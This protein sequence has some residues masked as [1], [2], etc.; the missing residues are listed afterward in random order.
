MGDKVTIP[1]SF[2]EQIGVADT[3]DSLRRHYMPIPIEG[4]AAPTTGAVF[5][6]N[7]AVQQLFPFERNITL[8][9]MHANLFCST[10]FAGGST[11][12]ILYALRGAS[13]VITLPIYAPTT[14]S[15]QWC[16]NSTTPAAGRAALTSTQGLRIYLNNTTNRA[17]H[18]S[19]ML[20]FK[21]ALD[22]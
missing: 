19:A 6:G 10:S 1:R 13:T 18:M 14:S 8:E 4:V 17:L 21:E 3:L 12:C 11:V 2:A 20:V 5:G 15:A 9:R 16:Q 7:S 22:S